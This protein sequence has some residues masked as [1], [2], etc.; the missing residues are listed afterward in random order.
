MGD[1]AQSRETTETPVMDIERIATALT[2]T[3]LLMVALM[4]TTLVITSL[5]VLI[6]GFGW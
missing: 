2:I 1:A 6:G 3:G 4:V 5:G